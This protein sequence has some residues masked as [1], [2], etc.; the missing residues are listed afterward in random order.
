LGN[1]TGALPI[2]L[3]MVPSWLTL[4]RTLLLCCWL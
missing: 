4:T 2:R 3:M 1:S